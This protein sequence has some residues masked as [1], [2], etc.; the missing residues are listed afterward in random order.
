MHSKCYMYL[1]ILS[2]CSIGVFQSRMVINIM[3]LFQKNIKLLLGFLS[4]NIWFD[5][6]FVNGFKVIRKIWIN[7]WYNYINVVFVI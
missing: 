6:N 7:I 4:V 3:I 1:F 2:M 5:Y